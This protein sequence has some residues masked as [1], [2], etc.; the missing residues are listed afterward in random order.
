MASAARLGLSVQR[1]PALRVL[2]RQSRALSVSSRFL[3]A[4]AQHSTK[5]LRR[6][7]HQNAL[8]PSPTETKP[9]RYLSIHDVI[10]DLVTPDLDTRTIS[11]GRLPSFAIE[12]DFRE[13]FA[14][15]GFK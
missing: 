7:H 12:D 3:P 13:L 10:D 4:F 2:T 11:V 14:E 5:L 15:S 6:T 9:S 1:L 8:S